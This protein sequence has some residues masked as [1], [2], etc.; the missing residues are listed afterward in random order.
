M[1]LTLSA[2]QINAGTL[3]INR[4]IASPAYFEAEVNTDRPFANVN[5]LVSAIQ[6]G[7]WVQASFSDGVTFPSSGYFEAVPASPVSGTWYDCGWVGQASAQI[8]KMQVKWTNLGGGT[9][10][11][12]TI[13]LYFLSNYDIQDRYKN[14]FYDNKT[15]FLKD[16]KSSTSIL[17]N[18][19]TVSD[20]YNTP[21]YFR[22][23]LYFKDTADSNKLYVHAF[24]I[25]NKLRFYERDVDNGSPLLETNLLQ[26]DRSGL[27]SDLITTANTLVRIRV[28]D[29]AMPVGWDTGAQVFLFLIQTTDNDSNVQRD[30]NYQTRYVEATTLTT[31]LDA[32]YGL[33]NGVWIAPNS[34]ITN[35]GGGIYEVTA[36]IDGSALTNGKKYR[37]IHVWR[38]NNAGFP[39]E[40]YPSGMGVNEHDFSFISNEYSCIDPASVPALGGL[41]VT[42]NSIKD[43]LNQYGSYLRVTVAE[44]LISTVAFDTTAYDTDV[45]RVKTFAQAIKKVKVLFY[46]TNLSDPAKMD[47]F[48]EFNGTKTTGWGVDTGLSVTEPTGNSIKVIVGYRTRYEDNMPNLY[49]LNGT[50]IEASLS[51]QDWRNRDVRIRFD[52]TLLNTDTNNQPLEDIFRIEQL[53]K[54]KDFDPENLLGFVESSLKD[55]DG[56]DIPFAC[57]GEG[58]WT[59]C[60]TLQPDAYD[61]KFLGGIERNPFGITT[62]KEEE[63]FTSPYMTQMTNDILSLVDED[64]V[65]D[66]ACMKIDVTQLNYKNQYRALGI[67]KRVPVNFS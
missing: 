57:A 51:T 3:S 5:E 11:K 63:S 56:N 28:K 6:V 32:N 29:N 40:T 43:Y 48:A 8:G 19:A 4:A 64:F 46:A 27:V 10:T 31:P 50:A 60:F 14:L 58:E 24:S 7:L 55:A 36:T 21:K 2:S 41:T 38:S 33:T 49:T 26:L 61:Y 35:L 22:A 12:V 44:R 52:F 16:A 20:V 47:V 17:N 15:K 53:I 18:N 23:T 66:Q 25:P 67:V 54:V 62:L 65:L 39:A 42:E 30:V 59:A 9:G 45:N 34:G 1:A 37:I 13:R